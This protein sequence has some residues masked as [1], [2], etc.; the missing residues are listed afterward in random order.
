MMDGLASALWLLLVCVDIRP[1]Y[2]AALGRVLDVNAL[3]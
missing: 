2:V 1:G 3:H